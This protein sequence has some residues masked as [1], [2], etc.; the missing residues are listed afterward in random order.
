MSGHKAR[1]NSG[2]I[3]AFFKN[4]PSSSKQE[5]EELPLTP[6]SGEQAKD[7]VDCTLK[8]GACQKI[9]IR[10]GLKRRM[11][12]RDGFTVRRLDGITQ[13]TKEKR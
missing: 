6:S 11:V 7:V 12:Y 10:N 1:K 5:Q 3:R 8:K 9:T 4:E 2:G 13:P